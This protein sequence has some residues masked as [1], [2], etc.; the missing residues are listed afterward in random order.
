MSDDRAAA[1]SPNPISAR[2]RGLRWGIA[3]AIVLCVVLIT[4]IGAFVLSGAAATKSLTA[5]YAPK[6]TLVFVAVRTDLPGDQHQKL[7]D[8][9]THFPGFADR[10]QFD[11]AFDNLLNRITG[12][13]SPDLTYTW[14]FKPWIEGEI[15]VAI[16]GLGSTGAALPQPFP[17]GLSLPAVPDGVAIISLKDRTAGEQ[18]LSSE[19][20]KTGLTF[21]P[22]TYAGTTVYVAQG[23]ASDLSL[24]RLSTAYAFTD[25]VLVMGSED[26]VKAAL[27]APSKGS[28]ADD[29]NYK[30]A[31]A[32]LSGE[33]LAV[34]YVGLG[35]GIAEASPLLVLAGLLTPGEADFV[36]QR[37]PAWVGGSI[38]AE[39]NEIVV[40]M[41]MPR[42]AVLPLPGNHTSRLASRLPGSTVGVVEAHS[43]S[44]VVAASLEYWQAEDAPVRYRATAAMIAETLGRLDG[45]DWLGDGAAVLTRNGP[46][47]GGGIV[48]QATSAARASDTV[49]LINNLVAISGGGLGLTTREESYKGVAITIVT[50]PATE[51]MPAME[52]AVA[53]K[54]DLVIAGYTDAFV[55]SVMD[56]TPETSLAAQSNYKTV[57]AA[58]G[59]GNAASEYLDVSAIVGDI[60]RSM[61]GDSTVY[62]LYYKPYL[63]HIGGIGVAEIDGS[64]IVLRLVVTA[65]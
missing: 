7:A 25:K 28:L 8:F 2:G 33:S 34:F 12:A 64:T 63:D 31:M 44:A 40:R 32:S 65:R 3:G 17:A 54:D 19:V 13:V 38:R 48:V 62:D 1:V 43:L 26:A 6:N 24:S 20:A 51:A 22:Q 18:W 36:A 39:S 14:A 21:V 53:S 61:I 9:M 11:S 29:S 58:A 30:A 59:E 55:K 27:D 46:T 4:T 50:V 23:L 57:M 37:V 52:I 5:G 42:T 10:A 35:S 47:Y 56:T 41:T 60:G 45:L 15:S 16:T 49:A